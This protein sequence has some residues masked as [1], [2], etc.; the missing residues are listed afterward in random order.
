MD[1]GVGCGSLQGVRD[2]IFGIVDYL[3]VVVLLFLF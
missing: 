1:G 3:R 2:M